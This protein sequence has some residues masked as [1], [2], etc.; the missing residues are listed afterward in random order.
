MKYYEECV[1]RSE[2]Y[3]GNN[4]V[5]SFNFSWMYKIIKL[6]GGKLYFTIFIVDI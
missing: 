2:G 4:V 6:K 3:H 1:V 5:E